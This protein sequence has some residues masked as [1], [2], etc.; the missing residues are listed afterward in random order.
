MGIKLRHDAAAVALPSTNASG[1]K[2]GQQLVL[3]Q[4][5][6]KYQGQQAGYDRL[7]QL[8]RDMQQNAFQVD[9][10]V[11]Q[12]NFIQGRDQAQRKFQLERDAAEFERTRQ[13]QEANRQQAFMEDARKQSGRF[14]MDS[15]EKGEYDPVTARELRQNLIDES[16][17]LGNPSLDATQ[18]AEALQKIRAR[19][20]V[21]SANRQP[22]APPPT[23]QD[24]FD[25]SIVTGPDGMQYRQTA[26]GDF[27]PLEQNKNKRPSSAAEAFND[28]KTRDKYMADATAIITK[29]GEQPLTRE[30][31][32]EAADLARQLW[33][34]DNLPSAAPGLPGAAPAA[35]GES[36]SIL[37]TSPA[38]TPAAPMSQL[39]ERGLPPSPAAFPDEGMPP[40][41]EPER[42][43]MHAEWAGK[44]VEEKR[45][46]PNAWD[47]R[48]E[49][50]MDAEQ[51]WQI[52]HADLS[53]PK[54]TPQT[55]NVGGKPLAVTPGTLTPQETQGRQQIMSMPQ[56]D[57][58]K[59]LMPY[60][61]QFKGKTIDQILED[62]ETKARYDELSKQGLTTG[63]Y[64]QDILNHMDDTLQNNVLNGAGQTKP[65]AYVG[66]RA[67]EITD[68]K[69]KA[70]VAKMP[71]PKTEDEVKAI[72]G[73]YFI[74]PNGII[75]GTRR[76]S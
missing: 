69:A 6:Q 68:P 34:D 7:F 8:G 42:N 29:G 31:R 53:K 62:P 61:P 2:Y 20:A 1:A 13:Q 74:D 36:K 24:M 22:V 10:D 56:E 35:P 41:P 25:K 16:E 73:P 60:D 30:S 70:E 23:A 38:P 43:A 59:A 66:M 39:P 28:P 26:K 14:I 58:I 45:A 21:L 55:V 12:Q 47:N 54:D 18:R 76:Q 57:R 72:R 75:R 46:I 37:D 40:Q 15:I 71:R 9:R 5:Q 65:D 32:K 64:R 50:E 11:R 17:A 4:Q 63:N 27:E 44:T 3:Q 51:K 48:T 52:D 49:A 33:E 19:R 67:D